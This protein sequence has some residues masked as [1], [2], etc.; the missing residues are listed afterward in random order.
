MCSGTV[1]ARGK[2]YVFMVIEYDVESTSSDR[3][4]KSSNPKYLKAFLFFFLLSLSLILLLLI[5]FID[6]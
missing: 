5:Y 6:E 2:V 1:Y 3:R 4:V